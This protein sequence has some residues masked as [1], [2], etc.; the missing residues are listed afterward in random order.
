MIKNMHPLPWI[1]DLFDQLKG[2][3]M[4]LKID[5]RSGYHQVHIKE[6]DIYGNYEFVVVPFGLN[7]A[8]NTFMCLMNNVLHP[9]LETFMIIFIIDIMIYFKNEEENAEH[10]IIVLRLIIE[11]QLYSKVSKCSLFQ[12]KVNYLGHVVSKEGIEL[13]LENIR[14]IMELETPRNVDEVR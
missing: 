14:A 12:M 1:Y 6:E 3:T 7:N 2:E 11:H 5:L 8:S 10:L 9:Y 4:F 13:G